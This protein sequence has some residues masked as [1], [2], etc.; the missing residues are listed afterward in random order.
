MRG[1][2]YS[3]WGV[4]SLADGFLAGGAGSVVG[5]LWRIPDRTTAELMNVFYRNLRNS[6]GNSSF[7]LRQAQL[8][9]LHSKQPHPYFWAA[10]VLESANRR[11]DRH[12]L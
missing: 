4:R 11:F 2:D 6:H 7:A 12:A 10:F 9:Q 3:G 1:Q 8:W 5:T